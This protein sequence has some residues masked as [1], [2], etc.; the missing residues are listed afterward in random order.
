MTSF[1]R[2]SKVSSGY[3]TEAVDAFMADARAAY[4]SDSPMSSVTS[5]SVRQ[6]SFP[7]QRGGYSVEQ[8]DGALERLEIALAERERER[9]I[10]KE[11]WEGYTKRLRDSSTE[12]L[13]RLSRPK[14]KR[15][16]R[17]AFLAAGYKVTDVDDF[18]TRVVAYLESGASLSSDEVRN[19]TFR[20]QRG[21]YNERQ[22][23][24]VLDAVIEAILASGRR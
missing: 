1:P 2:T 16:R 7:M 15:F 14:G 6:V 12:V 23:D 21:G 13:A 8:V 3:D 17:A 11:G 20:S 4:D 9:A 24:F 22:V 19:V 10:E 5:T 18:A